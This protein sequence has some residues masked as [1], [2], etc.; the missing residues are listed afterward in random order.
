M[1]QRYEVLKN[2][3]SYKNENTTYWNLNYVDKTVLRVIFIT[4]GI[5]IRIKQMS[6][7][8]NLSF[9]IKTLAKK[10]KVI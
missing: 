8:N 6:Q 2:Y 7:I 10:N 3:D 1:S 9:Q 4:L 5:Y